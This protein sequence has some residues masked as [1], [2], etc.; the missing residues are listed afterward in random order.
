MNT[1]GFYTSRHIIG[2][3]TWI[4]LAEMLIIPT[5][6]ITVAFLTRKLGPEGYGLFTLAITIVIW[7]ELTITTAFSRSIEKFVSEAHDWRLIGT[8][9]VRLHLVIGVLSALALWGLSVPISMLL[10]EPAIAKYLRLFAIDIPIFCLAQ[11]HK[12]ILVGMGRFYERALTSAGRWTSRVVLIVIFVELG[13]SLEGAIFGSIGASLVE[14]VVGRF[15]IQPSLFKR[16]T[17]AVRQLWFYALPLFFY[18]ISV[19]IFE[20]LD[21]YALKVLGGTAAQAGFYGAA[22]NL[23]LLPGIFAMALVP[24]LL[25]SLSRTLRDGENEHAQTIARNALRV[26]FWLLPMAGMIAGA[27]EDISEFVFGPS[28]HSSG[29]LLAVLIFGA[30]ARSIIGVATSVMIAN[31]RPDLPLVLFGPL[32]PLSIGAYI[33]VIPSYQ[34]VGAA[35]VTTLSACTTALIMI[36]TIYRI[37]HVRPPIATVLRC[38]LASVLAWVL[39]AAWPAHGSYLLI[40]LCVIFFLIGLGLFLSGEFSVT[41]FRL[42]WSIFHKES[43]AVSTAEDI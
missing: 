24:P 15:Y 21:L 32:I 6:L 25:S 31:N 8:S 36:A 3:T 27:G 4:F 18:V 5:G 37:W 13:L 14:L 11:A 1:K 12:S 2:G 22:Q 28:F 19:R 17:V 43:L 10:N 38:S 42:L 35:Y 16:T 30:V 41:H 7:L 39:S 33:M 20:K 40:K 9:A 34:A 29:P 26:M 23:A